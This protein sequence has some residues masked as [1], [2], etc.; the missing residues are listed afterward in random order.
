MPQITISQKHVW[1]LESSYAY[2]SFKTRLESSFAFVYFFGTLNYTLVLYASNY[3][4]V[5][6]RV[7]INY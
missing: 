1:K 7:K 2:V 5:P 4:S 6:F 3:S